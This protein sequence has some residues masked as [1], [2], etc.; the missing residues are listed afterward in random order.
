MLTDHRS[1][2]LRP[3]GLPVLDW[4]VGAGTAD[5]HPGGRLEVRAAAGTDWTNDAL[6]GPAQHAAALLGFEAPGRFA[7]SA[8]AGVASA[9]RTTF[10]AAALAIWGDRDHWAKI[11]FEYSPHGEAMVVSVV[12]NVWSDDCNSTVVVDAHVHLRVSRVS[13]RAWAFHSSPDGQHW[14]F[15]RL[16]RL[17][18]DGPVQVGFL[19]QAPQGDTCVA[20]FDAIAFS[21]DPPADLRDGS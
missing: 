7:L 18:W 17:E 1:L 9:P 12:T 6:G 4:G 5:L 8:R 14:D 2:P 11:C 20:T 3:A 21:A 19:A 10:D 13:D 15:V 16:F